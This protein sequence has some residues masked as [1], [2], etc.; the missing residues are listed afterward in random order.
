MRTKLPFFE[1]DEM[2][3][4]DSCPKHITILYLVSN[5]VLSKVSTAQ[6]L[7]LAV[8]TWSFEEDYGYLTMRD[9]GFYALINRRIRSLCVSKKSTRV[10]ANLINGLINDL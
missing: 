10:W 1:N 4:Y 7:K 5:Y 8:R 2:S 3:R 9:D 6:R